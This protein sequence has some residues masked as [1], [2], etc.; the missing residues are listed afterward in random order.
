MIII[1]G[2]IA[3]GKS[4]VENIITNFGVSCIDSD[5]WFKTIY[6]HSDQCHTIKSQLF[7]ESNISGV[8]FNHPN[9]ETF[10][11]RVAMA[12]CTFLNSHDF[13]VVFTG[14]YFKFKEVLPV[15]KFVVTVERKD[16]ASAALSRDTH[17]SPELTMK[18]INSQTTREERIAKSD[19]VVYND[20]DIESL[21]HTLHYLIGIFK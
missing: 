6:S 1:T 20:G 17:R 18:I 21:E 11:Q 3:C 8:A 5:V 16:H 15:P 2:G 4:T 7:G 10:C 14:E 9:W 13:D 19:F 12:F